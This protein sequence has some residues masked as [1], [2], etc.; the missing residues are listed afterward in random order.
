MFLE[1]YVFALK[2]AVGLNGLV[3]G[4]GIGKGKQDLTGM[5]METLKS[6][7]VSVRPEIP[8]GKA[9]S[10]LSTLEIVN[11]L[12][13]GIRLSKARSSDL[14]WEAVWPRLLAR[15]WHS[16]QPNNGSVA[17]SK[18]YLV[19]LIPGIKKFSRRKLVKGDHYFDSVSDVLSK[20]ASDPG[21]LEIE[22]S[23]N[24]EEN[25]WSDETKLDKEDFP[26]QQRHCYLKPRTPNHSTD[27]VKFTV[28]DTSLANG[29]ACKVRELRSLPVEIMNTFTNRSQSKD[30][31]GDTSDDSTDESSSSHS[32]SG[33]GEPNDLKVIETN[34]GKMVS[35]GGKDFENDTSNK[36]FAVNGPDLTN[37]PA[38]IPKDKDTDICNDTRPK[39]AMKCQLSR[40][41]RPESRN[42][43]ASPVTKRP[44]KK[45]PCTGKDTNCSTAN[46]RLGPSL[47]QEASCCA[48][49]SSFSENII[50]QVDPSQEK[51]SSS[52][53]SRGVSTVASSEGLPGNHMDV[54]D[55]PAKPQPRALIDLNIPV[56]SDAE[57]DEVFTSNVS[58]RHNDQKSNEPPESSSAVNTSRIVANPEPEPNISSRRQS[59]RNRPLTTKVL[60]ALAC[61]FLDTKQKQKRKSKDAFPQ[62]KLNSRPSRRS[63]ARVGTPESINSSSA[64]PSLEETG[65]A[66]NA[67]NNGDALSKL[68]FSSHIV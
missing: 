4:V 38:K 40:K 11:Y 26:D 49:N 48:E 7:Q 1:E 43:P 46:T 41:M 29:K 21:L 62:E 64:D 65:T 37:I 28:V 25:G 24:K 66:I 6:N 53:S 67:S 31:G 15:G 34:M 58:E 51:L 59:T 17:G 45:P 42:H 32:L 12:T 35:F 14:F 30:D 60:E 19:F 56:T 20:V 33:K 8:V 18:H 61:G 47:L 13:G 44:R 57:A 10:T 36:R 23:K 54:Q 27:A 68:G 2:D 16:E 5:A 55:S 3:E 22:G 52:S 9:C 63:R 50:C 39:K